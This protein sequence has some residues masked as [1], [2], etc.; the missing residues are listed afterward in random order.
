MPA[1]GSFTSTED[2]ALFSAIGRLVI[3]W[4]H[5]EAGLQATI[6][7][8][9]F[10]LEGAHHEQILPR[11]LNKKLAYLRRAIT[12]IAGDEIADPWLAFFD[13]VARE[14]DQRH[15]I[16]HGFIIQHAEATGAAKAIRVIHE[17]ERTKLK[18]VELSTISI[19]QAANRAQK[20]ARRALLFPMAVHEFCSD[21]QNNSAPN[22]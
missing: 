8:V 4:A 20:L 7:I 9:H 6:E 5:L 21:G 1:D 13:D 22:H 10:S 14:S 18:P 11:A 3:S 12:R 16:I 2:E 17:R 15:D 19:L